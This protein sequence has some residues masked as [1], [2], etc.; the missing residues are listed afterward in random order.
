MQICLRRVWSI[1][2]PGSPA[3]EFAVRL[4]VFEFRV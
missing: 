4:S 1:G 3:S 2:G